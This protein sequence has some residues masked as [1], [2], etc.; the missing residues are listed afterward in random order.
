MKKDEPQVKNFWNGFLAGG[1]VAAL[2]LYALGT[3]NG[4]NGL[5]T[6]IAFSEDMEKNVGTLLHH[7][8]RASDKKVVKKQG[9]LLES[10]STVL[11]K[12]Q[13]ATKN[14]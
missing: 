11:D 8:S 2:I 5:K 1:A 14:A 7:V 9:S 4:R 12:I 13:T 6:L 10:I 3:K